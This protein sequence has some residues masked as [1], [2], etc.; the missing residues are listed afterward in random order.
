MCVTLPNSLGSLQQVAKATVCVNI[1][2]HTNSITFILL[3]IGVSPHHQGLHIVAEVQ[4]CK[5]LFSSAVSVAGS[6]WNSQSELTL[7]LGNS[8]Q[9][10]TR[11]HIMLHTMH[12]W[13]QGHPSIKGTLKMAGF[14]EVHCHAIG[15]QHGVSPSFAITGVLRTIP[16]QTP[17]NSIGTKQPRPC[18]KVVVFFLCVGGGQPQSFIL[19]ELSQFFQALYSLRYLQA[20]VY[21]FMGYCLGGCTWTTEAAELIN[22]QPPWSQFCTWNL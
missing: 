2:W 5:S 9:R 13:K 20:G 12:P 8:M 15:S 3:H 19:G 14:D 6:I 21:N 17:V 18:A 22:L 4:M 16:L 11:A 10:N 1:G 7:H